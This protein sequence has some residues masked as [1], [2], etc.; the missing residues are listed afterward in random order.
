MPFTRCP[1]CHLPLLAEEAQQPLCPAC[2]APLSTAA[3]DQLHLVQPQAALPPGLR[4]NFWLF[5]SGLALLAIALGGV[6]LVYQQSFSP[7]I[8]DQG[9]GAKENETGPIA[10]SVPVTELRP[11]APD[12]R[13]PTPVEK[14]AVVE[15]ESKTEAKKDEPPRAEPKPEPIPPPRPQ[16]PGPR[17]GILILGEERQIHLPDGEYT[18]EDLNGGKR[19]KL[20]GKVRILRVGLVDGGSTL[21]A[22]GLE[23]K[24]IILA[25]KIDG[26]STVRLL[27]P[28]GSVEFR[29]PVSGESRLEV[30]APHGRVSFTQPTLSRSKAGSKIDGQAQVTITAREVDF[31]GILSGTA[32]KVMVNLTRG[33][34][35]RFARIE[36][37][38]RLLYRKV[39]PADPEPR[40]LGSSVRLPAELKRID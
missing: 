37:S 30:E 20:T 9:T 5:G 10:V 3:S 2:G 14:D 29:E 1:H 31:R 39:E 7:G 40:V 17:R 22:S 26:Q 8:G 27:A 38:T 11:S 19:V 18:L 16:D 32:T 12:P 34:M 36:G 28:G 13:P 24:E 15:A 23:A 6:W 33:G 25:R 4:T 35:L 21:D